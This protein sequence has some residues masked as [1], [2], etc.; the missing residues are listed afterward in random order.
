VSDASQDGN[1]VPPD[2]MSCVH[3]DDCTGPNICSSGYACQGG[4]C[5]PTG[6][7]QNCDDGVPCTDDSCDAQSNKCVHTPNDSNCPNGEYCD[8]VK[9]CVQTLPCTSGSSVCDRLNTNACDGLWSCDP[10][11]M[12]CVQGAA[13]CAMVTNAMTACTQGSDAGVSGDAGNP[14]VTCSWTCDTGFIHIVWNSGVPSQVTSFGAPP[15]AGGCECHQTS[16]TDVPD[17]T[18]SDPGFV[19]ENCDGIDGTV[20]DAIF[21]DVAS[22][23][24]NNAGTIDKP[25]KTIQAGVNTAG[26]ASPPKSV[27]ISKGTYTEH[28][29]LVNGVSIYGGYD[30][31][32][33]WQRSVAN[34][35]MIA[36]QITAGVDAFNLASSFTIQFVSITSEDASGTT[37]GGGGNSSYGIRLVNNSGGATVQGC[38]VAA[39]AGATGSTTSPNG[40]TGAGGGTGG[41][42]I[43]EAQGVGGVSSCGAIGGAGGPGVGNITPGNSGLQGSTVNGGGTGAPPG[44]GGG[45]GYCNTVSAG[46]GGNAPPVGS[47]GGNGG[48]GVNAAV[49]A[50]L[51]TF[52]SGG[53]YLPVKGAVGVSPGNPGGGGGGGGSGGGTQHGCGFANLSC[54]ESDS[55]GGGGGGGG[56]CGGA[57]GGGGAGGGGSFAIIAAS[58]TLTSSMNHFTSGAG[59]NGGPG[60]NGGQGGSG[61]S[62]GQGGQNT[63]AG[64]HP[65]GNGANGSGGG[66]GGEGGGGSGGPGGPSACIAF[67]GTSPVS[68]GDVCTSGA[69]GQGGQG[70]SNGVSAAASGPAGSTGT[71]D[72]P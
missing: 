70:G 35:T 16:M 31:S 32:N 24:D 33:Q 50:A 2:A 15:P 1:G 51:G 9:N 56:G 11:K 7:P 26:A 14:L 19:D 36:S 53:N 52:D 58:T 69:G 60:G 44:P 34:I 28:V 3:N 22:G 48:P 46:N 64:D 40:A 38:T 6:K 72:V 68:S 12:Y 49:G 18:G 55:G 62:G 54:C 66:G 23:N 25:K 65:A 42:A 17:Y 45:A 37:T 39:G 57:P 8:P 5:I 4:L 10:T 67:S 47:N 43:S 41:D 20:A 21:V 13:P 29:S 30:A 61:G 71:V 59:G 63:N 27:Y